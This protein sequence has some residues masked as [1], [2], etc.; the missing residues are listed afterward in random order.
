MKIIVLLLIIINFLNA[1]IVVVTNKNSHFKEIPKDIIQY[2]YLAKTNN[3]DDIKVVPILSSDE[4]L[5]NE[6]C[7]KVLCKSPSQYNSYWIRLVFTGRKPI[8]KRYDFNDVVKK[9]N[10]LNT[11]AYINKE[12]IKEEWKIIYEDN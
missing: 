5:H 2:I 6:F 10:E 11:I 7:D 12:D 3:I 8:A 1:Q 4:K 9:L